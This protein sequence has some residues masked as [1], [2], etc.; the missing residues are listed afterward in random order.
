MG[1]TG[2]LLTL[3]DRAQRMATLKDLVH[4][5]PVAA[6]GTLHEGRPFVSMVPFAVLPD[7]SAMVI[8]VSHLATHT[9][10][11]LD[12][13]AV[14][15]MVVAPLT[16]ELTPQELPRVTIQGQ[17]VPCDATGPKYAAAKSVYV[18]R[19]LQSAGMFDFA[20]F[21]LFLIEPTSARYVGG[22]ARAATLGSDALADVL[23][24]ER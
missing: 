8:H 10:D 13:P 17:A 15:L 11:M 2:A 21:Q 20:D 4:R 3:L 22:F 19:F 23:R 6:L 7:G 1:L 12:N 14:S 24:Q 9:K 5:Q 18:E 16:P